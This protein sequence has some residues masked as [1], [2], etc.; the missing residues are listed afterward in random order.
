VGNQISRNK[1]GGV[2]NRGSGATMGA[3]PGGG[4][5]HQGVTGMHSPAAVTVFNSTSALL[6]T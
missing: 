3:T 1:G 5:A 4:S 6:V 2:E